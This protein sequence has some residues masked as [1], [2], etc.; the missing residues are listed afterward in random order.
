MKCLPPDRKPDI[1][2]PCRWV[3]KVFG[4]DEVLLTEAI[5]GIMPASS[6]DLTLSR[7]SRHGK[8]LCMNLALTVVSD[9]DRNAI[10]EA[11]IGHSQVMLVL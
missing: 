9:S 8:Y 2:Y 11:L 6:Y 1:E 3:F 7:S 4:T 5:A 10:Y